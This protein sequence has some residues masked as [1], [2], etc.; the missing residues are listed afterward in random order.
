MRFRNTSHEAR[1]EQASIRDQNSP[2]EMPRLR[3]KVDPPTPGPGE[4]DY[5]FRRCRFCDE[6]FRDVLNCS[7]GHPRHG[8]EVYRVPLALSDLPSVGPGNEQ[9]IPPPPSASERSGRRE[10][11]REHRRARSSYRRDRSQDRET[12][13][14]SR[15]KESKGKGKGKETSSRRD[16]SKERDKETSSRRERSKSRDKGAPSRRERSKERSVRDSLS[17]E[18]RITH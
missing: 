15:R 9:S 4:L 17:L 11:R 1:L 12:G 3:P 2:D 13:A 16:Q 8:S 6:V 14:S 18:K 7:H 5:R 10:G